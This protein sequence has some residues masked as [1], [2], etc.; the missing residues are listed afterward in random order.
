MTDYKISYG[1]KGL[2]DIL[3]DESVEVKVGDDVTFH[4]REK[5]KVG[6]I[7]ISSNDPNSTSLENEAL[8]KIDE[9]LRI[10]LFFL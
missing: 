1:I 9:R 8:V 6:T 3:S 7:I 2:Y 10:H 4:M 5:E